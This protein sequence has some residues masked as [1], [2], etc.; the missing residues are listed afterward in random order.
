MIWWNQMHL[1][2]N[3]DFKRA[4]AKSLSRWCNNSGGKN[5]VASNMVHS[6]PYDFFYFRRCTKE[7]RETYLHYTDLGP[8]TWHAP[9][10]I[11]TQNPWLPGR[12]IWPLEYILLHDMADSFANSHNNHSCFLWLWTQ[13]ACYIFYH[14]LNSHPHL[15]N[16]HLLHTHPSISILHHTINL[17]EISNNK[18]W[19]NK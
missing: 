12:R 10:K 5:G 14:R 15:K 3:L 2:D 13:N 16:I 7:G 18:I 19:K 4:I 6:L 17:T 9:S 1:L 11:W 8:N